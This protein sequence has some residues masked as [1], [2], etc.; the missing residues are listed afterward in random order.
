MMHLTSRER[1]KR[2]LR[3]RPVDR[4]AAFE[5]FWSDTRDA[6]VAQGHIGKDESLEDHFNLDL[7]VQWTFNSVADLDFKEEIVEETEET[8]L[9]R[10][11][12]GALLRW[13]KNRS[14]TPEHVDFAVKDRAAWEEITRPH[15]VNAANDR[16]RIDF[17]A[18]R[19]A[20]AHARE[21]GAFFCWGGVNVFE[22]MHPVCGHVNM[23]LGM[24]LDPDWVKD[25]CRVYADLIIRLMEVL[26]A[27]EGLPDGIYFFED[28]GFKER[29]FMSPRM[30]KEII[31]P[32][33]KRTFDFC[34]ARGLPVVVHSCGFVEPLV[35]GLI[36]AGM[37]CLQAM[38]VKAGMDL[39]RLKKLYGDRIAFCGGMDIRTLE[40]N[41]PAAVE[42]ELAKN[43]PAAM[44]GSGYILHT[45]HSV[46]TRVKYETYKYFL[47]RGRAMGTY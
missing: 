30:Y 25:M 33:H 17:E 15:L 42:A 2:I 14:G 13:W 11:G 10:S 45:D 29:P 36:E 22:L 43:L 5:S 6:W 3:R 16:R 44:A 32:S 31:W 26:F 12:N 46:S 7:R 4:V 21:R 47:E 40:T 41:D 38:E 24:A 18:Y 23:L 34:R 35:P 20:R 1:V 19:A 39:V 37:D 27:E 9:V 28:M 8:K